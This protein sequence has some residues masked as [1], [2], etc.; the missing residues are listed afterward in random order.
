MI[1][2]QEMN[3]GNCSLKINDNV[4]VI[5]GSDKGRRGKILKIDRRKGRVIVEGV[6]KR[7]KNMKKSQEHP[8]GGVLN[9]EFPINLSNVQLF[10]DKCKK[11]RRIAVQM[12]DDNKIRVCRSCGKSLD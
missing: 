11:G 5:T 6:N 3:S 8:K 10:C 12:K 2:G 4:I 7:N 1:K 9:I